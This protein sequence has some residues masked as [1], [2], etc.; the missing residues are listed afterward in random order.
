[1]VLLSVDLLVKENFP[2]I[3]LLITVGSQAPYLYEIDVLHSLRFEDI[4]VDERLP[5]HFPAWFNVY[6]QRDFLSY[7][8]AGIFGSKV[9]DFEVDN[10]QPFMRSHSAYW[11][12]P[13]MWDEIIRQVQVV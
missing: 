5:A 8:G 2:Q 12:N 6:D 11:S 4:P 1:M 10:R 7:I 3:E 9:T 13:V